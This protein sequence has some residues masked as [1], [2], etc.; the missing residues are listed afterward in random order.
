MPVRS[1]LA[2]MICAATMLV[3]AHSAW[4]GLSAQATP[5]K[6]HVI[7]KA[8]APTMREILVSNDGPDPVVVNVRLADW[9]LD[10]NGDMVLLD[11][12]VTPSSLAGHVSFEPSSFSLQSGESGRIRVTLTLPETGPATLWGVVL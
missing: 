2:P 5:S 7:T 3:V 9:K 10:A 12:G 4:A 11:P 1:H 6:L 8:G